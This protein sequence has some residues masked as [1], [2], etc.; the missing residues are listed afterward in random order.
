MHQG[1]KAYLG[2][3]SVKIERLG[4]RVTAPIKR[5][6]LGCRNRFI[7]RT[8]TAKNVKNMLSVVH[9]HV[10]FTA[11]LLIK[12]EDGRKTRESNEILF[13]NKIVKLHGFY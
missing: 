11:V 8:C 1:G 6:T 4:V 10:C 3:N 12:V 13:S 9:L 7:I 5:T 2:R